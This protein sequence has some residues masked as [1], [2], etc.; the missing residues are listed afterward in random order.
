MS[1]TSARFA[2]LR[3]L[4]SRAKD[5]DSKAQRAFLDSECADDRVLRGELEDLLAIADEPSSSFLRAP[6]ALTVDGSDQALPSCPGF[7]ILERAAAGANG[8]V[9]RAR[10]AQSGRE[11]ALKVLRTDAADRE[12]ARRFERE[13]AI[14][15]QLRHPSIAE[16]VAAN[17]GGA[18]HVAPWIA[19]E[20]VDGLTL[21]AHVQ[22]QRLGIHE[23][24]TLFAEICAA[25][26]HAHRHG[27]IHRDLKPA[28]I[29]VDASGAPRVLDFGIARLLE[30]ANTASTEHTRTGA[31][32]GTLAYMAPEQA[33][34]ELELVGPRSDV[35]ALG[36]ILFELLT[37]RSPR[38]L[39]GLDLL[40]AVRV[41][42]DGEPLRLRD[43]RP[44]LPADLDLV[45]SRAL[46]PTP[47]N[48]YP[49]AAEL[50][51]DVRAILARRS[52][53]PPRWRALRR[54]ARFVRRHRALTVTVAVLALVLGSAL[55]A[56]LYGLQAERRQVAATGRTLEWLATQLLR[57]A[58]SFDSGHV[59]R[60]LEELCARLDT[61]LLQ[62]SN[63]TALR[64][65]LASALEERASLAQ[66]RGDLSSQEQLARKAL[67]IRSALL[68]SNPSDFASRVRTASLHAKLG[69]AARDAGKLAERDEH[70]GEALAL[71]EQLVLERP[72]D[73][74]LREDLGWSLARCGE[75]AA[76][77]GDQ[78]Q[79][80]QLNTRR[81]DDAER[82][83]QADP[84]NWTFAYNLSHALYY[85]AGFCE[86]RGDLEQALDKARRSDEAAVRAAALDPL[87]RDLVL[88]RVH[89]RRRTAAYA[90]LLGDVD[91]ARRDAEVA[92]GLAEQLATIDP[93]GVTHVELLT[94][95]ARELVRLADLSGAPGARARAASAL[96]R[97]ADLAR[98]M[99]QEETA[100]T[101]LRMAVGYRDASAAAGPQSEDR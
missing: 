28:N 65:A 1:A 57:R 14:L 38:D 41:V 5:L 89:V 7:R 12:S 49:T 50:G 21:D 17:V 85:A 99:A 36:V 44:D 35:Y 86:L 68:A 29:V 51:D 10:H 55:A 64:A 98:F 46:E 6:F 53:K 73:L 62:D 71:N 81:L 34:G 63:D 23:V 31:L 79:A 100:A 97:T 8:I 61:H 60:D 25:V 27:V 20:W 75:A 24:L 9:Y 95:T 59:E 87:R 13:A 54:A 18:E 32:L 83:V 82:L 11:V 19:T 80:E 47:A 92:L 101:L 94:S 93:R 74:E 66:A 40:T 58:P 96:E 43:L 70:F 84:D 4:F 78:E 2:R 52:V 37:A 16:L 33:R 90:S 72:Q 48:R 39:R 22:S 42:S 88:W 69:E 15:A 3:E 91:A 76:E 30:R 26:A 67:A 56:S 45:L 77:R